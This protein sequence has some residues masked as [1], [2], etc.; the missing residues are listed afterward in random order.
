[1]DKQ[2]KFQFNEV[3][4]EEICKIETL[5]EAFKLV[6]RNKGAPGVDDKTIDEFENNLQ[7]E[8][9][10]LRQEVLNWK[11]K[12]KPVKSIMVPKIR[13]TV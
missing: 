10:E 9:E 6:K 5:T 13:T 3:K 8:L 12:P 11:Y 4:L 7:V 2:H 1:M